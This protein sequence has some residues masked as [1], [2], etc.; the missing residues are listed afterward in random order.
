MA[1]AVECFM[2]SKNKRTIEEQKNGGFDEDVI[3]CR[4]IE[5]SACLVFDEVR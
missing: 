4:W 1:G 3:K 2:S 5:W